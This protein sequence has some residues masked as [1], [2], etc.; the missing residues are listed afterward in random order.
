[1]REFLHSVPARLG[2]SNAGLWTFV[3]LFVATFAG[4]LAIVTFLVVR[5]PAD[6]FVR[7]RAQTGLTWM[8]VAGMILK[9]VFG[10]VL[11]L[12]GI[13][14]SIPGVP[15]QGV[16]TILVGLMLTDIPG[17]RTLERWIVRNGAVKRALDGVRQKFGKPPIDV[18]W[19][20]R[21]RP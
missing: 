10:V 5:M 2:L 6:Y 1:M 20:E 9:N 4:S 21:T 16:L 17:V 3:L 14:L 8:H 11:V 19:S 15:G 12:V 13:V 7:R 18:D